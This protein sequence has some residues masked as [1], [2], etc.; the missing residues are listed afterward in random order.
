MLGHAVGGTSEEHLELGEPVSFKMGST[1][2]L[3]SG[4]RHNI[5]SLDAHYVRK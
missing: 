3:C 4:G 1:L 2:A 5:L